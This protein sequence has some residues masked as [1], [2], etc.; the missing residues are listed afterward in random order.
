MQMVDDATG[1][2][3]MLLSEEETTLAAL[4]LLDMWIE[5]HGVPAGLYTDRKSVYW[6]AREPT[7]EE[8]L[9]GVRP[10]T[11]FGKVCASLGITIT[12]AHSPQAKGRVERANGVAQ[13]RLVKE[14][15]LAGASTIEEGNEVIAT[16]FLDAC[17][18]TRAGLCGRLPPRPRARRGPRGGLA[19]AGGACAH[20]RLHAQTRRACA[21]RSSSS[22]VCGWRGPCSPS[23]GA[24]MAP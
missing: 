8:E 11:A 2:R 12:V 22:R 17:V 24:W 23:P 16:G 5:R 14:L 7:I 4:Q 9:Q 10:L 1:V 18:R 20:V 21:P 15:R 19:R 13:D 6:S 3:M